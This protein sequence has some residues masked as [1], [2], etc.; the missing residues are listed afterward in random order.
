MKLLTL[1]EQNTPKRL[2]PKLDCPP[3]PCCS[4]CH[5]PVTYMSELE[6]IFPHASSKSASLRFAHLIVDA[7]SDGDVVTYHQLRI[8]MLSY[9]AVQE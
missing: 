3:Q 5:R 8:I 4:P 6:R 2:R 7:K 1:G 9:F